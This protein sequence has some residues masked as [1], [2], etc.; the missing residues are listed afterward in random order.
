MTG[1]RALA[2]FVAAFALAASA[3]IALPMDALQGP[4][5]AQASAATDVDQF[6]TPRLVIPKADANDDAH[7]AVPRLWLG[8]IGH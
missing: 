3:L 2:I 5:E 4:Q 8:P 7:A 1:P 6:A